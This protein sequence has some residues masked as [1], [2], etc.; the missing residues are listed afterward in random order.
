MNEYRSSIISSVEND[1]TEK[2]YMR[3]DAI[4]K[5][6]NGKFKISEKQFIQ[7]MENMWVSGEFTSAERILRCIE[8][9][10]EISSKDLIRGEIHIFIMDLFKILKKRLDLSMDLNLEDLLWGKYTTEKMNSKDQTQS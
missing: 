8:S 3:L 6:R 9:D 10:P 2:A 4:R 5:K 1:A 7:E